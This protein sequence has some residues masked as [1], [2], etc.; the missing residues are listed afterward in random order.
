MYDLRIEL[1]LWPAQSSYGSI[2]KKNAIEQYR[3]QNPD[4]LTHGIWIQIDRFVF[5]TGC[6]YTVYYQYNTQII[7]PQGPL[8][9]SNMHQGV[10]NKN[11]PNDRHVQW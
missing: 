1:C 9:I 5:F 4:L 11:H 8:G 7:S 3:V 2:F 10:I 6:V